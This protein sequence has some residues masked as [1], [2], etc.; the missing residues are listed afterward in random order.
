MAGVHE[1]HAVDVARYRWGGLLLSLSG[2][3]TAEGGMVAEALA[4]AHGDTF[5]W[6]KPRD[7]RAGLS[8]LHEFIHLQQD[9]ATGLGAWDHLTTRHCI[10]EA[11]NLARWLVFRTDD[12][13]YR[14]LIAERLTNLGGPALERMV[15]VLRAIEDDSVAL[16]QLGGGRWDTDA[17]RAA[18]ERW[19][20]VSPDQPLDDYSLR[21]LLEG[22]A[23]SVVYDQ[24]RGSLA[25]DESWA[26]LERYK[27]L[28]RMPTMQDVY[29]RT[30]GDVTLAFVNGTP[31][32][33][34][35]AAVFDQMV[36]FTRWLIDITQSYPPPSMIATYGADSV[37]FDPV[38]RYAVLLRSLNRL[39]QD[40]SDDVTRALVAGDVWTAES[41]LLGACPFPY[42]SS[43]EI[44]RAWLPTLEALS[45]EGD[46][47]APLFRL[48][49][50]AIGHRLETGRGKG[51][52][53]FVDAKIPV[54]MIIE[55]LGIRGVLV[56][57]QLTE[58]VRKPLLSALAQRNVDLELH[59][60]ILADGT[61]AC[62]YAR[63]QVCDARQPVCS[64]G[65]D[66]LG[67]LPDTEACSIRNDLTSLGYWI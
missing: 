34:V 4:D 55:G 50:D 65:I 59:D 9:V 62:P 66:R 63:I 21:F 38:V 25:S 5:R 35:F 13:P 54:Q 58:E 24:V 18:L 2:S 42:P 33:E 7:V 22:E 48:R 52:R 27:T 40:A 19:E 49:R 16:R 31:T 20:G 11:V 30:F 1:L 64:E 41:V 67:R 14:R 37:M 17:A 6:T 8:L 3:A 53:E 23:A 39:S 61:F 60:L 44:Y 47:D 43:L 45:D 15:E 57:D 36:L 10:L 51:L 28:W 56:G 29:R 32:P 26:E 46:W 12:P